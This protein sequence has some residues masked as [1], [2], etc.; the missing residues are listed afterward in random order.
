MNKQLKR[1]VST[2]PKNVL[3]IR[4][5][6]T[7]ICNFNCEYCFPGSVLNINKFP[8]N[9]NTVIKN[10]RILLDEY[11]TSHKKDFFRIN[12]AGGGE[13]SLWPHLA[14]FCR[15]IK[16]YHNVELKLTTNGS[17]KKE[18][19]EKNTQD[20]DKFTMSCHYKEVDIDRFIEN[21][22]FLWSQ[23]KQLGALM[24][25][26]AQ[27]WK[28]CENLLNQMYQ[29]RYSWP[30]QAKEVVNAEGLDWDCYTQEQKDFFK[31]SLKR[32]PDSKWILE[33]INEIQYYQSIAMFEDDDAIPASPN[34]YISQTG[35]NFKGWNCAI[36]LEN[37]V[38][39]H[40]GQVTGSCQE[41]VFKGVN[42]N[43]FSED[44]ESDFK[45]SQM[46]LKVIKCTLDCCSCQPDT[47]V[48][49]WKS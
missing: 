25:M 20:I 10:F 41:D 34:F 5:W 49:K 6:P 2:T 21:C 13:P 19:F 44:F 3:D 32:V 47:H 8:N 35:N 36:A 14:F 7:D 23:E 9:V 39:N 33:N 15:E 1:I 11:V 40:S 46:Q 16:K 37:L 42:L 22:D 26:D 24:L 43:L 29:S 38:I 27:N 30:I 31:N 28:Q 18:W 48:T 4:F 17:R 12:I 45:K